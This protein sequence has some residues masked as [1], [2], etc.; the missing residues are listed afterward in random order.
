MKETIS[1][2][3]I[4]L[5]S[6]GRS[7][8]EACILPRR[9]VKV[10]AVCDLYED[11]CIEAAVMVEKAGQSRPVITGDYKA[12][13]GLAGLDA[14]LITS[15]WTPHIEIACAAMKAGLYTAVEVAGAFS[16][17]D[18]WRLV[19]IYEETGTQCMFLENCCFG[20][21][22]LM[23]LNMV[24]H[25]LFGEIVHCAGGYHHDLRMELAG[26]PKNRHYRLDEYIHRNCEN[27]PTHELGPI[28]EI[29]NINRGNRMLKLNSIASKA[30]GLRSVI[31]D[32][33]GQDAVRIAQG[34]I[35]T[36]VI[37]CAG[38]ETIVLT[39]DTTLPRAYSRGFEVRGT[40][41]MFFEDN[42]SIFLDSEHRAFEFNGKGLWG[43]ADSY[44]EK[45]EHPIWKQYIKDGIQGGHDG[46]DWLEFSAFFK[47]VREGSPVPIDV[48][49]MASWMSITPLSED[50]IAMGGM[51]VPIPD[52][53]NGKWITRKDRVFQ[54]P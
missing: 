29:L 51:P 53:T 10:A 50:S 45:Y 24:R 46:M 49:D 28:A 42:R 32:C 33:G 11:R 44:F 43:N 12:V 6:R 19:H 20:R 39:L 22:E 18:C 40:K 37:T 2:G 16:I 4:G 3:I 17:N 9:D 15:G 5:G 38:G 48:Y 23:V 31:P 41:G 34:D 25:G 21:Y 54:T 47:A 13:I 35:V 14:V 30:A 7:L 36:T 52:F 27:Y 26:S 8:M 1:I